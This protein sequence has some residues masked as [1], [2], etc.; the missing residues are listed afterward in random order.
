MTRLHHTNIRILNAKRSLAFYRAIGL[1][2]VGTAALGPGY[3]LLYLAG[4]PGD[5]PTIELVVNDTDDPE[6]DRSP[7]AGHVGLEVE[8]LDQ[9][10]TA[11]AALGVEP[12]GPPS[13]PAGRADLNP[14]AF[15]RDPDG[16]RVELLQATWRVPRDEV[17]GVL[18][19]AVSG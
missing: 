19:E 7:G 3:T 18:V 13:H 4:A 14:V 8:D 10:L 6:Y 17:P 11:L 1:Q 12:E 9:V 15:V 16:V 5:E 2:H